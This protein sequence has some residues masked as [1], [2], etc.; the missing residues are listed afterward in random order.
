MTAMEVLSGKIF[1][2]ILCILMNVGA[3]WSHYKFKHL[4]QNAKQTVGN[5]NAVEEKS[6]LKIIKIRLPQIIFQ[7]DTGKTIEYVD[8]H[9]KKPFTVGSTVAIVL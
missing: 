6:F 1:S 2:I 5:I 9:H 4:Q 8:Q 3:I 7:T